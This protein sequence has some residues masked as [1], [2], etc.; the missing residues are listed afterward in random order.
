[1]SEYRESQRLIARAESALKQRDIEQARTLFGEAAAIQRCLVESL[2][3]DRARTRSVFGLSAAALFYKANALTEAERLAHRYMAEEWLEER[4]RN[5]LEELLK[6]IW[7]ERRMMEAGLQVS[8][9]PLSFVLSGP[10]IHHGLAPRDIVDAMAKTVTTYIRRMAAW[11]NHEPFSRPQPTATRD[12]AEAYRALVSEGISGSYRMD[13]YL[14]QEQLSLDLEGVASRAASP[15]E[16]IDACVDFARLVQEHDPQGVRAFVSD[17]AYRGT[18]MR[19]VRV[20]VPDGKE[21]SEVQIRKPEEPR[22]KAVRFVAE[23]R[24]QVNELIRTCSR[25]GIAQRQARSERLIGVLRAVD[26]D[27]AMLRLVR[28][29]DEC[30]IEIPPALDDIVGPLLNKK[31][32]V[33]AH[34]P[35][36][37]TQT[38]I[39]EDIEFAREGIEEG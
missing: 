14:S 29:D 12:I 35:R 2:P 15:S 9:K 1:M 37:R 26:L 3:P 27:K 4:S 21:L 7:N 6:R 17:E 10:A 30:K 24:P 38:W 39:G 18:L 34:M 19:L 23:H 32:L 25:S 8:A 13:Y 33:Q 28:G 11:R 5:G 36:R 16:I 20:L 31:V 22:E